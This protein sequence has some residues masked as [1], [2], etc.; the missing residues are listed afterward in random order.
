MRIFKYSLL[1][2]SLMA[3]TGCLENT[4][5]PSNNQASQ[6]VAQGGVQATAE[7]FETLKNRVIPDFVASAKSTATKKGTTLEVLA[8]E[9]LQREREIEQEDGTKVKEKFW[10]PEGYWHDVNYKQIEKPGWSPREHLDRLV[11]LAAT[12]NEN[13]E[14]ELGTA[15]SNALIYWLE[16]DPQSWNWWWHDIGIPKRIGYSAVMAKEALSEALSKRVAEYLPSV[17]NYSP[18]NPNSPIPK[19]ANRTDIALA[20]LNHGIL[21]DD[22]EMVGK[23]IADIE[24]T[25]G[26]STEAG[27]QHDYSFHQHGPQLYTSGYGPVMV[28]IRG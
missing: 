4:S 3:V 28:Y 12:Y 9:Y 1:A 14:P 24:D 22:A 10:N 13:P 26:I 2:M 23:A 17:P 25:I 8:A 11:I 27:V 20:V 18:N 6:Q 19:A 16:A 7:D 21:A 5:S 15:I